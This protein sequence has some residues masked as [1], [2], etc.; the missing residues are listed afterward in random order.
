MKK[1]I[2][3]ISTGGTIT[4]GE[5]KSEGGLV[6]QAHGLSIYTHLPQIEDFAEVELYEF[7]NLPSPHITLQD[8]FELSSY[9]R[10]KIAEELYDGIVITHGTDTLEETAYFLD[11]TLET[12]IPVVFTAAMRSQTELGVDGPR[13]LWGAIT[14]ASSDEAKY[15]GVL[16]VMNDEIHEARSVT[17]TYTSNTS[18][19]KSISYGPLGYV[20]EDGVF[21]GRESL[22]QKHEKFRITH[23]KDQVDLHTCYAGMRSNLLDASLYANVEGV[24]LEALGRGNV[25]P[26]I[27]TSIKKFIDKEIPVIICSR[28]HLGRVLPVY[29]YEG[30]GKKLAEMGAIFGGDLLGIKARI[31]LNIVLSI[32]D[33][34]IEIRKI[35]LARC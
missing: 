31:L 3:L 8:M 26:S 29:A 20:D 19:F 35:F 6:P 4:M 27:V 1:R 9:V 25:P 32:T 15:K 23:I 2:L 28:C 5:D 13:N 14:T 21:F 24:V 10:R 34:P 18:T 7:E 12:S 30:G 17:K 33:D 16:V 22:F 11:L